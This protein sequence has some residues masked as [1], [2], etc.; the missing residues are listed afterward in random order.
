M[1]AGYFCAILVAIIFMLY[2]DGAVGVLMLAFLLLMPVISLVMTLWVRRSLTVSLRL[3]DTCAKREPLTAEIVLKKET[4]LPVPFLRLHFYAD[5]HF[6]PLN[7]K[8]EPLPDAPVE[9][10]NPFADAAARRRWRKAM[11]VQ[12]T[13]E[14]LPMCLSMGLET[15]RSFQV[16][17]QGRFCGSGTVALRELRLS[18]YLAM[19]RFKLKQECAGRILVTPEIPELKANTELFRAVSTA[20]AAADE[21]TEMTPT[22][23]ASAVPGYDHRDYVPGDSLKRINW[24]LSTKRHKL[25]VRL[26]EPISMARLSVILDFRRKPDGQPE[27][28]TLANEELLIETALGFL[29]LCARSGY[30]CT[31]YYPDTAP[32]YDFGKS[33]TPRECGC[34]WG[35]VS[36]DDAS[37]LE[38]EALHIL[39]GGFCEAGFV[40]TETLPPAL[41][42]DPGAVLLYFTGS[43]N[44]EVFHALGSMQSETYT[45]AP[46][47]AAGRISVPA[48]STLWLV[49]ENHRLRPAK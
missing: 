2:M 35:S 37:Q 30:P 44:D 45:I 28:H 9:T 4:R 22:A 7:P 8:A 24:K 39:R 32:V 19:F 36:V 12:L 41:A 43:G 14:T 26:D 10:G 34:E 40:R 48:G 31:L 42:Q 46:E 15:E 13:P 20:V 3:P 23:S 27:A 49:T 21:E 33:V 1:T 16:A 25:Q 5:A 47:H 6:L 18:D 11:R 29:V 17:L 38:T